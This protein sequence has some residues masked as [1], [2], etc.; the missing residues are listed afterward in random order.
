MEALNSPPAI[1]FQC[2]NDHLCQAHNRDSKPTNS[3][4]SSDVVA[5][6]GVASESKDAGTADTT[7]PAGQ[8]SCN[9][10][11][12]GEDGLLRQCGKLC[13]NAS[14]LS[15]HKKRHR[16]RKPLDVEHNE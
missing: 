16:K 9:V 12:V 6:D 3:C 1:Q 13:R 10:I 15:D 7:R 14:A 2:A 4:N 8:T 5:S 11:E